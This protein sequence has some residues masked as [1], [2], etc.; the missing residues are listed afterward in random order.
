[1]E[2]LIEKVFGVALCAGVLALLGLYS[3]SSDHTA[4]G[5]TA[6]TFKVNQTQ[7]ERMHDDMRTSYYVQLG[8]K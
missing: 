7:F 5:M 6:N 2:K 4:T 3:A 1:M 8:Q